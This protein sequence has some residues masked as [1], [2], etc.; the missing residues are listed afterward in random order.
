MTDGQQISKDSSVVEDQRRQTR[1]NASCNK[2]IESIGDVIDLN[3]TNGDRTMIVPVKQHGRFLI[4][5]V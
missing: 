5:L 4:T 3:K 1:S 2:K